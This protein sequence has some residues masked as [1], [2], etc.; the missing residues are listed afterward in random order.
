MRMIFLKFVAGLTALALLAGP[1]FAGA[2]DDAKA[3]GLV[4][5]TPTG[6]VAAVEGSP[7]PDIA[8]LVETI[9]AKRQAA[10]AQIATETGTT[11][12]AVAAVTAEK[13]YR[14]SP[15][16]EYLLVDGQWVQR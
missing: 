13:L 14:E 8:A 11:I 16:G 1:A 9:N 3:A 15:P 2:L 6:Y 7:A 10:Y 12:E 5:E 4:G